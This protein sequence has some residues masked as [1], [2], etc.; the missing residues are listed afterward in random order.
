M[1]LHSDSYLI[2][3]TYR[4]AEPE[5]TSES[6]N[7]TYLFY[8]EESMPREEQ[9]RLRANRCFPD[10]Y[11]CVL[12]HVQLLATLWTVACQAPLSMGLP[13]QEYWNVLPFPS[14]GDLSDLGIEPQYP[15]LQADSLPS[16]SFLQIMRGCCTHPLLS[17]FYISRELQQGHF[18]PP[19]LGEESAPLALG[20]ALRQKN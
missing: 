20:K 4:V 10:T 6:S 16:E 9:S 3:V 1:G 19:P 13:R 15:T 17:P 2:F 11:M 5:R 14:P 7:P 8:K 12:S 18:I